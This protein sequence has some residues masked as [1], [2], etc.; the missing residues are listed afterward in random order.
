MIW[1]CVQTVQITKY[2]VLALFIPIGPKKYCF[3]ATKL[4]PTCLAELVLEDSLSDCPCYN[5]PEHTITESQSLLDSEK[6]GTWP[7][8][9]GWSASGWVSRIHSDSKA[10]ATAK[11]WESWSQHCRAGCHY[12]FR[13]QSYWVSS[14]LCWLGIARVAEPGWSWLAGVLNFR[15]SMEKN[16]RV[17]R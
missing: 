1:S 16:K 11:G 12:P 8:Q 10:I 9:K 4:L 2:L 14:W 17:A 3:A 5:L 15:T 7:H 6:Q 13:P